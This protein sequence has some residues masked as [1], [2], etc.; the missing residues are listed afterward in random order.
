M[1][2]KKAF[3]KLKSEK[4]TNNFSLFGEDVVL[5]SLLSSGL[6]ILVLI[7]IEVKDLSENRTSFQS[8]IQRLLGGIH[9][10]AS[11]HKNLF[12]IDQADVIGSFLVAVSLMIAA[13]GGIGG[14][15]ILVP[16]LI[17]VFG[18]HPKYA[19]PLCNSTVFGSSITNVF[20]NV[21]KRHP[22]ADRP[23]IDWD[24]VLLM[25]P[26]TIAG[27]VRLYTP[28]LFSFDALKIL[29]EAIS[30]ILCSFLSFKCNRLSA[31]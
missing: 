8:N 9:F 6:I 16:L 20:L 7:F 28:S 29:K 30:H 12:P 18:F 5:K 1:V 10:P 2:E 21:S 4:T 17:M 27:A 23:L 22:E 19:I 31:Q 25:E 26:L 15:G 24:L 11:Q 14:G 13:S 3:V